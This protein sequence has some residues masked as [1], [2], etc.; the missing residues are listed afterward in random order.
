MASQPQLPL[1]K[2]VSL[3]AVQAIDRWSYARKLRGKGIS[4]TLAK[5][6]RYW[7]SF[8]IAK[9]PRA[10]ADKVRH[11]LTEIVTTYQREAQRVHHRLKKDRTVS[12][13]YR[14]TMA[15]AIIFA[16]DYKGKAR[17]L[18]RE[19]SPRFYGLAGQYINARAYSA[20]IHRSGFTPALR[21][22]NRGGPQ[23]NTGRL[24]KYRHPTG[25]L[26]HRFNEQAA[27]ILAEN[28]ATSADKPFRRT[29]RA[30]GITVV[31]GSVLDIA[32]NEVVAMIEG[33]LRTD[34]IASARDAGFDASEDTRTNAAFARMMNQAA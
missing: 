21:L 26:A 3:S 12:D 33:F 16:L 14:G 24:P 30:G 13:K 10:D 6:M 31:A 8:A 11:K 17:A 28:W 34:L 20:G 18:A 22:L 29:G 4:D 23:P 32:F 19:R 25:R 1:V 9:I 27:Y 5:V 7:L 2:V 15:A